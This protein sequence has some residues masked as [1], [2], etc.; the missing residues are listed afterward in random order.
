MVTGNDVVKKA[1]E[2]I[3]YPYRWGGDAPSEGGF[4]CSGL[5]Y[6]AYT[7]LGISISRTTYTQINDGRKI[8]DKNKLQPGDLIF[9]F[10][11]A[12]VPQH[13]LMYSGNGYVIEAKYEGTKVS[14]HNKWNWEGVG[15]RILKDEPVAPTTPVPPKNPQPPTPPVESGTF[16]RVICGSYKDRVNA[17]SQ[18]EKL[19][20]AGFDSFLAIYKDNTGSFF[21]IVAGSYKDRENAIEQQNKLKKAGFDSFLIA[22]KE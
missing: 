11:T 18:Q 12:G 5:V 22:F 10:D 9:N 15:V 16:F 1:R 21:R 20:K 14:E 13:V 3:G 17:V 4:D 6:Y 2:L 19:K 8:T 7:S